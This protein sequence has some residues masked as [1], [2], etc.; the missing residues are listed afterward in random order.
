M[1]VIISKKMFSKLRL[2]GKNCLLILF[3]LL[4]SLAFSQQINK[5]TPLQMKQ[6]IDTL[7]HY[8]EETHI[9][10]YYRY[11]KDKFYKDVSLVKKN[12]T[13][14]L[15]LIDFYLKIEPL[16]AKLEDGHTDLPIPQREYESKNP[17]ELPYAFKLTPDKPYIVCESVKGSYTPQIPGNSEII[18]INGHSAKKIVNDIIN[19][20]TGE[21]P[22]F[23]AEYGAENF[24]FFIEEL[25][26]TNGK[27]KIKYTHNSKVNSIVIDGVRQN[28]LLA[29]EDL[30]NKA[31][32]EEKKEVDNNF[33][34]TI[35]NNIAIINFKVFDWNGFKEF[36]DSTFSVIKDKKINNL[37]INLIDNPGGDSDVGDAFL[38]YFL[39]KPFKQYDRVDVKFSKLYKDRLRAHI[40]SKEPTKEQ[41]E[42]L[43]KKNGT[44]ETLYLN[45]NTI[46][47]NP[48]RY[49]GNIYLLINSQTYSSAADFAQ[50]FKFYKRGIIIGE[51]TGGLIKSFGD[52][53]T[54][55]LPN[56][57]L[58]YTISS[59]LYYNIGANKNDF[60]GVVP[61][62][63][64]SKEKALEKALEI[65]ERSN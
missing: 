24:S 2:S 44:I 27:Y 19:L 14:E 30:Y 6:D 34:L 62:I 37:V 32:P 13:N 22:V 57:D 11:P 59:T 52:I 16:L 65:I 10:P 8:L 56:S 55:H 61:D 48:L 5:L 36:A 64:T 21:T 15:D 20:N 4:S 1:R 45:N 25:Y 38:Q 29:N 46:S 3:L 49:H 60:I 18:S 39:D 17:F 47:D 40:G 58:K 31:L 23:R 42:V 26:K 53:V 50:C 12:L 9:N 35:Q 54:T 41:I 51:E 63:V 28:E 43:T 33:T 7:I